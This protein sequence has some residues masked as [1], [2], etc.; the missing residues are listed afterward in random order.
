MIKNEAWVEETVAYYRRVLIMH[1]L[2]VLKST[3]L[4]HLAVYLGTA[5][6]DITLNDL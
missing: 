3:C 5:M 2:R 6:R 1:G 4:F